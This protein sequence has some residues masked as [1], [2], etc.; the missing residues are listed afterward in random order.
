MSSAQSLEQLNYAYARVQDDGLVY[1]S[2]SDT[3]V[4]IASAEV[5]LAEGEARLTA[6]PG[7]I[8]SYAARSFADG[9]PLD[10]P[11]AAQ[12]TFADWLVFRSSEPDGTFGLVTLRVR[13][14]GA[15]D[16]TGAAYSRW[17]ASIQ[18]AGV[19]EYFEGYCGGG[20]CD[21]PSGQPFGEV[22]LG[23]FPIRWGEPQYYQVDGGTRISTPDPGPGSG[24][25]QLFELRHVGVVSA[26]DVFMQPVSNLVIQSDSGI[27]WTTEAPDPTAVVPGLGAVAAIGLCLCIAA[28]GIRA[29]R[30]RGARRSPRPARA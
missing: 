21:V 25:A 12:G 11:A 29:V 14:D 22:D 27:D 9:G 1:T 15:L 23:P 30:R 19:S 20:G 28:L 7:F 16:A 17:H 10:D 13:I 5:V 6:S 4:V 26:T 2:D 24:V 8:R 3:S 18:L